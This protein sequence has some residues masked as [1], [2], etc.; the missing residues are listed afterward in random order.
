MIEMS[1][2]LVL[3]VVTGLEDGGAESVLYRL[4]TADTS[5]QHAVISMM[6]EGKYGPLLRSAGIAVYCLEMPSGRLRINS[7]V[8]LLKIIKELEPDVVQ[9]WMYHADFI[10]GVCARLAGI[11]NVFW[12]IRHS[13]LSAGK[14]K[15]ST[16]VVARICAFLSKWVPK[17]IICCANKAKEV[18]EGLG[19]D[20]SKMVVIGN[21]YNLERLK[22]DFTSGDRLR[23]DLAI[24]KDELLLGMVGRFNVQ[25]NH[26]G[27][28]QV[29]ATL[30]FNN[31]RF[32]CALVG[33]GMHEEN[34]QLV[35]WIGQKNLQDD[36]FLLGQCSDVP[37]VMN[38]LDIHLLTS[39]FG[40]GFPNVLAE[41]MACGTP[42]VTT[43]V[44]D[45][46][47]IVGE[48]GWVV[49]PKSLDELTKAILSAI[50]EKKCRHQSWLLRKDL[51]RARIEKNFSI[52]RMVGAYQKVWGLN[53]KLG[54]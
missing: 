5:C 37:A 18:H 32:K 41:A 26:Y 51:S 19:Y 54:H 12:N 34:E 52:E 3:H 44:G 20:S 38:A 43:D 31:V 21:G 30:K 45:A 36:L 49:P 13:E 6:S 10:G 42:C 47:L 53:S 46:A 28:L 35:N 23:R 7:I 39:S 25:K 2:K 29:L 9:T 50:D 22:P 17:K 40:E 24:S 33:A 1:K 16:I 27:L 48:T 14:S 8:K 11:K 15:K 4:C